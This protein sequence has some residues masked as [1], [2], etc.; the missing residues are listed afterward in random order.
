MNRA[1]RAEKQ[2]HMAQPYSSELRPAFQPSAYLSE[3]QLLAKMGRK[4]GP[5]YKPDPNVKAFRD[6]K[7]T[8]VRQ[9]KSWAR[10]K[11]A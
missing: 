10:S 11:G 8:L 1:D 9:G 3:A 7:T 2:F 6:G 5:S 4:I